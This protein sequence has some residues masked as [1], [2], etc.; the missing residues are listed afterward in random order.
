MLKPV[1][2]GKMT[3]ELGAGVTT[4]MGVGRFDRDD[5]EELKTN[6][7]MIRGW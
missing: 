7:R 5:H 3:A 2:R 1:W 6:I 4:E